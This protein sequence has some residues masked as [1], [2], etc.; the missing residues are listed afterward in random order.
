MPNKVIDE[1]RVERKR[2]I[3]K[4]G[5][6]DQ[7]DDRHRHSEL[8]WAAVAYAS[9]EII[10]RRDDNR[11][12]GSISFCDAWPLRWARKWDKR[13]KHGHRRRLVIAAA[14]LVAEIE[15]LDRIDV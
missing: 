3:D 13:K 2:Q 1:I 15:R 8:L 14:L 11:Y 4:E 7:H 10:Y 5:W 12:A 6:G 9:P